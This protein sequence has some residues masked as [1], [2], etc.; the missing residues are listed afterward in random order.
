M[1]DTQ[2]SLACT[3]KTVGRLNVDVSCLKKMLNDVLIELDVFPDRLLNQAGLIY[4][5]TTIQTI[6]QVAPNDLYK[7]RSGINAAL[8]FY[9]N[10]FYRK[11]P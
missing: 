2:K 4:T 1:T 3:I 7:P 8:T 11:D 6:S 9:L 5:L 10:Y